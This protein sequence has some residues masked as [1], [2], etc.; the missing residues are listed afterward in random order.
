MKL[1]KEDKDWLE[2]ERKMIL[3]EIPMEEDDE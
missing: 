3:G 1:T 2:K